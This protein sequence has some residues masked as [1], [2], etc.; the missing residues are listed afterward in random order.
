[1]ELTKED[2]LDSLKSWVKYTPWEWT[3]NYCDEQGRCW[4]EIMGKW[5][6]IKP[7]D[8]YNTVTCLPYHINPINSM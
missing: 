5:K 8:A 6:L 1:M 3:S 4:F 7:E 2:Y